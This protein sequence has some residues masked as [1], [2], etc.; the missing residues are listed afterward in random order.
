[1]WRRILLWT[2]GI[3]LGL[4]LLLVAV[5]GVAVWILTPERLTPL[6]EKTASEYL[7]ADVSVGRVKLTYWETFPSLELEVD[8]LG[9][10][11]HSLQGLPA[12]QRALLPADADSLLWLRRLEGKVN[13]LKLLAMKVELRDVVLEE[14]R[15]N[16]VMLNDL[17]TNF[18]ILPPSGDAES[19][20]TGMVDISIN[21][22]TLRGGLDA[23]YFNAADT[24][25]MQLSLTPS[26]FV[27]EK[28]PEYALSTGGNA[29]LSIAGTPL[30]D[31]IPFS[32]NTRVDWRHDHPRNLTLRD[33]SLGVGPLSARINTSLDFTHDLTIESLDLS[34]MPLS[35]A[36]TIEWLPADYTASLTGL[37]TDMTVS[38]SL[39]L[40]E[41]YR[42]SGSALPPSMPQS[43]S[44]PHG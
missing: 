43:P 37:K 4:A 27:A 17:V 22:F 40:T 39:K 3:I 28:A 12:G 29:R 13:I 19:D 18:D 2:L 7:R 36:E 24:T 10:V 25:K 8:S 15:A 42:P 26:E 33:C 30:P 6:V 9:I 5:V 38:G 21:R 1:M 32:F 41:P 34:L 31:S 14:P 16:I 11:S 23:R 35:V 20:T 44:R